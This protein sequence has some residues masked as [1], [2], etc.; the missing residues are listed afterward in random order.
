MMYDMASVSRRET[1][2][3]ARGKARSAATPGGDVRGQTRAAHKTGKGLEQGSAR[4]IRAHTQGRPYR[5]HKKKPPTFAGGR[6]TIF[7]KVKG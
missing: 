4:N 7:E 5:A 6:L 3:V 1:I 2:S